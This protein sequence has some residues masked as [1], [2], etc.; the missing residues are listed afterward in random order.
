MNDDVKT[1]LTVDNTGQP[2]WTGGWPELPPGE[3]ETTFVPLVHR[4]LTADEVGV[5]ER[6]LEAKWDAE[7]EPSKRQA[8][9]VTFSDEL[10]A[11]E[12]VRRL[13]MLIE[14]EHVRD[15]VGRLMLERVPVD[16][17][18]AKKHPTLQYHHEDSQDSVGMLGVL[19]GITGCLPSG[20]GLVHA[21]V[22]QADGAL[23]K[24]G[25]SGQPSGQEQADEPQEAT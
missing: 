12:L 11:Q 2:S 14:N 1:M 4:Q 6:F 7:H 25:V 17:E 5:L 16:G 3:Y 10:F 24:F 23:V 13:N 18:T 22:E 15:A 9:K 8:T 19:N 20:Y 21:C